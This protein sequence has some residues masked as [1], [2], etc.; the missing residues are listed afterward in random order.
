MNVGR[1]SVMRCR[2]DVKVNRMNL[3]LES[4][5]FEEFDCFKYLGS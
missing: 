5:P 4:G 1:G 2:R 3:R